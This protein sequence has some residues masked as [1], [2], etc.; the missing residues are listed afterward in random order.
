MREFKFALL[1]LSV[2]LGGSTQAQSLWTTAEMD[3]K[4]AKNVTGN[5]GGEYRTTDGLGGTERWAVFAGVDYKPLKW[6][7][8][9]AE[10]KF[11]DC[12]NDSRTTKKDNVVDSYWQ[13]RHRLSL[14]AT[15]RYRTGRFTISLR[16]RY[17]Y[18]HSTEQ[19]V[20]KWDG[21]DG[22]AKSDEVI[23]AEDKHVLRSCLK[24]EYNVKGCALTP[25]ASVE[26]YNSLTD[27][28]SHE[29]MRYTIGADYDIN[30]HHA[31]T[32]FGRYIDKADGDEGDGFV[33]G[34]GYKFSL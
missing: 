17:Q 23:E 9:S 32:L 11:L 8:L 2:W 21:D 19:T 31:V 1:L 5:V 15:G 30:K 10:Y 26:A 3:F 25:F 14:S 13:P 22:S 12:W 34:V 29:K 33:I 18:T 28:F 7:K 20:P 4:M 24:A 16:E 6:L 27:G